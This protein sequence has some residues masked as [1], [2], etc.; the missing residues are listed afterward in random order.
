MD[1]ERIAIIRHRR[2]IAFAVISVLLAFVGYYF[3]G[4]GRDQTLA[5]AITAYA[6]LNVLNY[7]SV[8]TRI[9]EGSRGT[10]D[11]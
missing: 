9:P 8:L 6:L 2:L 5:Y 1:S 4:F 3:F 7:R 10:S 11:N